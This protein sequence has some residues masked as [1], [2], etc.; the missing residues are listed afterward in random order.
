MPVRESQRKRPHLGFTV[1]ADV[2]EWLL[3]LTNRSEWLERV[4]R[5]EMQREA[6]RRGSRQKRGRR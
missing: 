1:A 2:R 6:S 5:R 3:T 4:A